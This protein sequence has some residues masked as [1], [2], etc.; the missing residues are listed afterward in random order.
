MSLCRC[1][2]NKRPRNQ[3][4]CAICCDENKPLYNLPC[5]Q[6]SE[7][8][9]GF[10]DK[11][12]CHEC[13]RQLQDRNKCPFC[14]TEF[15]DTVTIEKKDLGAYPMKEQVVQAAHVV[16]KQKKR[17]VQK[18][19]MSMK[20]RDCYMQCCVPCCYVRYTLQSLFLA[21]AYAVITFVCAACLCSEGSDT[22][23]W[24][25]WLLSSLMAILALL[26]MIR[27][28]FNELFT[29]AANA[30]LG[31]YGALVLT[32]MLC[33]RPTCIWN[34]EYSVFLFLFCPF[35]TCCTV[36]TNIEIID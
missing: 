19:V 13:S 6:C 20:Y 5:Q 9:N 29:D 15:S 11:L 24:E 16:V 30:A 7:C 12:V 1:C 18:I 3:P 2:Y 17:C 10:S 33:L 27:I 36:R 21:L 25:C 22:V 14:S 35:C 4:S 23:C 26:V 31:I 32:G 8:E 28:F 34:M